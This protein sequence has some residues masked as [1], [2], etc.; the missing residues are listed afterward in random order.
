MRVVVA[1]VHENLFNG[2]AESVTVPTTE[3]EVTVLN[4]HEPLGA[5]LKPGMLTV[6]EKGKSESRTFEVTDGVLEVSSGQ[7]TVLL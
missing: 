6:K 7:A 1:K 5:V 4:G 2:D 3:G